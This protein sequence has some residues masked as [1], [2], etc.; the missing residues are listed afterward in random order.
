MGGKSLKKSWSAEE[1]EKALREKLEERKRRRKL[2][3]VFS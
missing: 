3:E 1:I 2:S